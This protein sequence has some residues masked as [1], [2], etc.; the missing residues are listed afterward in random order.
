[1]E[2]ALPSVSADPMVVLESLAES[3]QVTYD[4][5]RNSIEMV[6]ENVMIL[7]QQPLDSISFGFNAAA[8]LLGTLAHNVSEPPDSAARFF[9]RDIWSYQLAVENTESIRSTMK[10]FLVGVEDQGRELMDSF[11]E[12]NVK[13]D[14]FTAGIGMFYFERETDEKELSTY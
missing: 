9:Q 14:Q 7:G 12:T 13:D 2:I 5:S 6:V 1:M 11:I 8:S 4:E 10:Q 3:E